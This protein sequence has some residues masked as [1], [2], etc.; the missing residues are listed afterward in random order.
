LSF[1]LVIRSFFGAKML[2]LSEQ[3]LTLFWC[4]F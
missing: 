3:R 2:T 1:V 4:R